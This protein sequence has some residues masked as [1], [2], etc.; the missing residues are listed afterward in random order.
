MVTAA[1]K[2]KVRIGR[3]GV[4]PVPS[5]L[6][7]D[8]W[9]ESLADSLGRSLNTG[10][11]LGVGVVIR[12]NQP[13]AAHPHGSLTLRNARRETETFDFV[14]LRDRLSKR[15][16]SWW[17][18]SLPEV[19]T[20]RFPTRAGRWH[21]LTRGDPLFCVLDETRVRFNRMVFCGASESDWMVEVTSNYDGR[22]LPDLRHPT[23]LFAYGA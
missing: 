2:S 15:V 23:Q 22:V 4:L 3:P 21:D 1:K 20:W 12:V 19:T 17:K 6:A 9:A 10:Y 13:S 8:P 16:A 18:G 7:G 5:W 11:H 14:D